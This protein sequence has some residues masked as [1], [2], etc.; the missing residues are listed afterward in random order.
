MWKLPS[1][2]ISKHDLDR[3]HSGKRLYNF[4]KSHA[5]DVAVAADHFRE[6]L[7]NQLH[8]DLVL[9]NAVPEARLFGASIHWNALVNNDVDW[10]RALEELEAVDTFGSILVKNWWENAARAFSCQLIVQD[11]L[12]I[13]VSILRP[14]DKQLLSGSDDLKRLNKLAL[15]QE[16]LGAVGRPRR[17]CHEF[18][19]ICLTAELV[20]PFP[21]YI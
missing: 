6:R 12:W 9:L 10:L 19:L 13:Q 21:L 1:R 16:P 4:I 14:T 11:H 17:T 5:R 3:L 15:V 8:P 18:Y 2:L 20:A 7:L